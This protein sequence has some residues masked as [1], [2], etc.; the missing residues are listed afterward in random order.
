MR[1]PILFSIFIIIVCF[2]LVGCASY[3]DKDDV[4]K[5]QHSET[6]QISYT[7][8]SDTAHIDVTTGYTSGYG[9][10]Q[11]TPSEE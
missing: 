2:S 8:I 5:N 7:R 1:L 9:L 3:R 11:W 4:S 6:N 10:V